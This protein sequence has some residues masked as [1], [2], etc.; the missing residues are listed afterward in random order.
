MSE[1]YQ[2]LHDCPLFFSYHARQR[3]RRVGFTPAHRS[4]Y[5]EMRQLND[6]LQDLVRTDA[7]TIVNVKFRKSDQSPQSVKLQYKIQSHTHILVVGIA[8]HLNVI[9]L[10]P[11]IPKFT[12][13]EPVHMQAISEHD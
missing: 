7:L 11:E 3:C 4:K 12:F 1:F 5:C 10:Y 9:T 13:D 8:K 6:F 2:L